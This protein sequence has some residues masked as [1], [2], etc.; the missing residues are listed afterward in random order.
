MTTSYNQIEEI[1]S[2]LYQIYKLKKKTRRN[3]G[4]K[5]E[6]EEEEEEEEENDDDDDEEKEM[7]DEYD[8]QAEYFYF[9][10]KLLELLPFDFRSC[11]YVQKMFPLVTTALSPQDVYMQY[12]KGNLNYK[13]V[14]T[15]YRDIFLFYTNRDLYNMVTPNIDKSI[16]YIE[17]DLKVKRIL[18]LYCHMNLN[19]MSN[20]LRNIPIPSI[21]LTPSKFK[22]DD[23]HSFIKIV[24]DLDKE[25]KKCFNFIPY[26]RRTSRCKILNSAVY[27]LCDNIRLVNSQCFA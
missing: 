2:I 21:C 18:I 23:P 4:S 6:I 1:N 9:K 24:N 13:N 22:V 26:L 15:N 19:E 8:K 14:M 11:Y 16:W 17:T 20:M 27:Y 5:E 3:D 25:E 7:R 12:I 10:I